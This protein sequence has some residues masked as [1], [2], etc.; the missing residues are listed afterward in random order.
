MQRMCI[1]L[2]LITYVYLSFDNENFRMGIC[3]LQ[4]V[5]IFLSPKYSQAEFMYQ[6]PS[7][8]PAYVLIVQEKER[9]RQSNSKRYKIKFY[10]LECLPAAWNLFK[11]LVQELP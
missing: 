11:K 1:L 7:V 5:A 6:S 2:F 4:E 9:R 8:T 10:S 3:V